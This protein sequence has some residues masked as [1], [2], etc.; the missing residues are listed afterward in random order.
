MKVVMAP[1]SLNSSSRRDWFSLLA[2]PAA[3]FAFAKPKTFWTSKDP[4]TWTAEEKQ[5]L[6]TQS[7]WAQSGFARMDVEEKLRAAGARRVTGGRGRLGDSVQTPSPNSRPGDSSVPIGGEKLPPPPNTN[8]GDEI[9]FPV[10]ARW[11]SSA[12]VR[13]ALAGGG[14]SAVLPDLIGKFYVLHLRGLP[15]M[16]PPKPE[17]SRSKKKASSVE[18]TPNPNEGILQAVKAGSR[19]EIQGAAKNNIRTLACANLFAGR[20]PETWNE[21]LLLFPR[22]AAQQ[23]ITAADRMVTLESWFE[24]YHLVVKFALKDMLFQGELAL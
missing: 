21:V 3:A 22:D 1:P 2:Y 23:P 6:L 24:P 16:P 5:I 10:I 11:E 9:R 4:A 8:P 20:T 13:L 12:P 17:T 7:P 18:P 15:L 14:S 19:L